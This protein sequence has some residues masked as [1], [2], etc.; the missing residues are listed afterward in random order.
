M[1]FDPNHQD[2]RVQID[3]K[4]GFQELDMSGKKLILYFWLAGVVWVSACTGDVPS[5]LGQFSPCPDSP[6][7]VFTKAKDETHAIAPILYI[8]DREAAKK[9]LIKII[10]SLPRS[11][12]IMDKGDFIHVEFTSRL[13]R[14]VDDVEF[15]LAVEEG[16]IHFRSASRVGHSDLGVNRKRMEDIRL[17]FAS[18]EP[19]KTEIT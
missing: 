2:A 6:N 16:M 17:R 19:S 10:H 13:L 5:D 3:S 18:S 11:R 7:C 12:V 15:Y 9:R 8:E 4:I 1:D 14:F